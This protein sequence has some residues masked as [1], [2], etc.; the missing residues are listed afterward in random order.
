MHQAIAGKYALGYFESWNFESLMGVIDAAEAADAPVIIGFNGEF[1]SSTVRTLPERI[2]SYGALGR[3]AAEDARVPC[4]FIFN[5]CPHDD[6]V[7]RAVTAGF[8]LVM[9]VPDHDESHESYTMRTAAITA[10]AHAHGVAVEAEL[11]TLPFGADVPGDTTD[12]QQAAEFVA[13]TGVDLLAIS[14]GNVHVLLEGRRSLDLERIAALQAAVPV[15]LVL[16]GGT[17]I[18]DDSLREA[19]RLGVA[20]VN[21]GTALKQAYLSALR[22][23][24]DT[25]EANPH[26]LLGMGEPGDIMMAGR[27]AVRDAVLEKMDVLGCT[28]R[29]NYG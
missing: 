14:A 12:P 19:V 15:P 17:G 22:R 2:A 18:E 4:G 5:E 7:R 29:A 13:A 11:G 28:G 10:Y 24:L 21:Y 25:T 26:Q 20:K 8:N 23:A 1:M 9:P 16:H 27:E 3:A 6:W